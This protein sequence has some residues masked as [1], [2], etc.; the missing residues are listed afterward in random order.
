MT[1]G[2]NK[3]KETGFSQTL[4]GSDEPKETSPKQYEFKANC[5]LEYVRKF[6]E[7][8]HYS[9][10][11]EVAAKYCFALVSNRVGIVGVAIYSKPA[12]NSI[13]KLYA[14]KEDDVVELRRLVCIDDTPKNTES[15][16]VGKT[17][18]WLVL[19]TQHK[20]MV[21][22]ADPSLRTC[23]DESP[24]PRRNLRPLCRSVLYW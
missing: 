14:E 12:M 19:N 5:P 9:R 8:H 23:E 22:Y 3:S 20:A 6:M 10:S 1:D 18:R 16:F 15:Y 17:L 7:Q 21:T 24:L 4:F 11:A 2:Y 13:F